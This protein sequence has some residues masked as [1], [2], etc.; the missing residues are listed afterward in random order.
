M[1]QPTEAFRNAQLFDLGMGYVIVTRWRG[2]AE[3]EAGG[4]LI[5]AHC[6]GVKNAFY[7]RL[8][9]SEYKARVLDK[10]IPINDRIR[11]TPPTARKLVEAALKYAGDLGFAPH[12][13]YKKACRVFGGLNPQ[14]SSE[15]FVF[16]K[17]G[18][19]YYVQGPDDSQAMV[20]RVMRQLRT[21]CG[22]GGFH[23]ILAVGKPGS[24]D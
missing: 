20:D 10:I 16:G 12:P 4:F 9:E 15:E 3:A 5:D 13:D 24:F 22:P 11:M 8:P 23:Y 18:K 6:L 1:N 21:R 2:G 7:V 19:P 14:E 17:D